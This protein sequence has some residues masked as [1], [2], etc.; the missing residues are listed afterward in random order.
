MGYLAFQVGICDRNITY[1][2][3]S[4]PM[5]F[6]LHSWGSPTRSKMQ[7]SHIN[8]GSPIA[9]E[10]STPFGKGLSRSSSTLNLRSSTGFAMGPTGTPTVCKL[11]YGILEY[12]VYDMS[13]IVPGHQRYVK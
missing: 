12:R 6:L 13:D 10:P 8:G 5:I 11:V 3:L 7:K 2:G 9:L 1:L 4:I